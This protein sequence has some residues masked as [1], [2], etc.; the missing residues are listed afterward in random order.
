MGKR[1]IIVA[2]ALGALLFGGAFVAFNWTNIKRLQTVNTLFDEDKIVQNFS[3]MD[4]AFLHQQLDGSP[5]PY[6]F[7]KAPQPLPENVTINSF[8]K[9]RSLCRKTSPLIMAKSGTSKSS[10]R[11][12]TQRG[13][14]FSKT[15]SLSRRR[16][17]P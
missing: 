9:P 17:H 10:S 4:K 14:L 13:S 8:Q 5:T 3:N 15:G 16:H 1:R 11:I 6:I 12:W 2:V 7:P